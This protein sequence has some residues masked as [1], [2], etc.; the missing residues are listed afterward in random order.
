MSARIPKFPLLYRL[1]KATL[2]YA[3]F[4][5]KVWGIDGVVWDDFGITQNSKPSSGAFVN[6]TEITLDANGTLTL[7]TSANPQEK[8]QYFSGDLLFAGAKLFE[9][10]VT[11]QG[12][13]AEGYTPIYWRKAKDPA[14][15]SYFTCDKNQGSEGLCSID[16]NVDA[17]QTPIHK[18][19]WIEV[20]TLTIDQNIR[21]NLTPNGRVKTIFSNSGTLEFDG[22]FFADLREQE[23]TFTDPKINGTRKV[24]IEHYGVQTTVNT[25]KKDFPVQ[26]YGDI[27]SAGQR[28]YLNLLTRDSIFEGHFD[29]GDSPHNFS[30]NDVTMTNGATANV[31]LSFLQAT[32]DAPQRFT[33]MMSGGSSAI[34]NATFD[35][36]RYALLDFSVSNSTLY[37]N[38]SYSQ[39]SN[40]TRGAKDNTRIALNNNGTWISNQSAYADEIYFNV[41]L[42]QQAKPTALNAPYEF[43]TPLLNHSGSGGVVD[44]RYS[45]FNNTLRSFERFDANNR[46]ILNSKLIAGNNGVFKIYGVFNRNLWSKDASG[47]T[48][49]TDQIITQKVQ[50]N[51]YIEIFWNPNNFDQ[52][53]FSQDLVGDRIV[54]AKQLSTAQEGNFI[55]GTTSVGLYEYTTNLKKE[56]LLDNVGG[57]I[58]YEWVIGRL[59]EA[60]M[61]SSPRP[62]FLSKTLNTLFA[63][64]YKTF[65]S[66]TQTLHQRMGDLRHFD[67]IAGAYVKTNYSLLYSKPTSQEISAFTHIED[68]ALGA[69]FGTFSF[70]GKHFFG[71]SL[72]ITP[73]QDM[74]EDGAYEGNT[75]A[76]GIS[77]YQTS[78]F[79]SG[80]YT[81]VLLKYTFANHQYNLYS[82][83]L[84]GNRFEFNSHSLIS[85]FEIGYKMKLP[86]KTPHFDYSFYYLK[87]QFNLDFGVILGSDVMNLHHSSDYAIRAKYLFSLPIKPSFSVDFGRRFDNE[88]L[89]GDVFLTLGAEYAFNAGNTLELSTPYNEGIFS[90]SGVFNLKLGVGS[91]IMLMNGA[92]FYFDLSSKFLGRVAPV[93]NISAGAR[94]PIGEKHQRHSSPAS[95]PTIY[96]DMRGRIR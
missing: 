59:E 47:E 86:I 21:L 92:R 46:I 52:D 77:L 22:R 29:I 95:S 24:V 25:Y 5:A 39:A 4:L 28:F 36:T 87:P 64:P 30:Y 1:E 96:G 17:T 70:L 74:G 6:S 93:L 84:N 57:H 34:I 41:D 56:N 19:L 14:I 67:S 33:L 72:N 63:I 55:G 7:S 85:S 94:I 71:A 32:N 50:G 78:L 90:P 43:P 83:D 61:P 35:R 37:A 54:V 76:Y 15:L 88:R 23:G 44:L 65:L 69:D 26:I 91:N 10:N 38:L 20:G 89:L 45:D 3:V 9:I 66:Q 79:S 49:A 8:Q 27:V 82:Q 18:L 16:L 13:T 48:I 11:T 31:D 73:I 80:F 53:L 42:P 51:H 58:G 75:L 2:A 62:S 60:Q 40:Q 12:A 81:D 68:I